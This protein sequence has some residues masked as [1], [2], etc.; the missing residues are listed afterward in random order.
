MSLSK[1]VSITYPLN[2][3][4]NTRDKVHTGSSNIEV[5]ESIADGQTAK[6][7]TLAID[8]SAVSLLVIYSDKDITIK[9]NSS[10]S[11]DDT[12]TVSAG[13][14]LIWYTGCGTTFF[15]GTDT[16]VIYVANA[17]GSEA[18]LQISGLQDATP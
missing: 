8:V 15:L 5:S 9:T 12:L 13:V 1:T 3:G 14:P 7:I 6:A 17:S 11:P 18:A 4:S 16:T 2:G 10:G